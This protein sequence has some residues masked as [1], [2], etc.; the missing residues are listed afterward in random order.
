MEEP[1]LFNPSNPEHRHFIPQLAKIHVACI[2]T[3]K[4]IA[5]FLPP[6]ELDKIIKW[7]EEQVHEV[8]YGAREI[9]MQLVSLGQGHGSSSKEVA[10]FVMLL[11]RVGPDGKLT[12]ET[13]PF[14][15][16]VLKLLV[17]PK[18]RNQGIARRVMTKLEEVAF[19]TGV[20]LL[21]CE[22]AQQPGLR[23]DPKELNF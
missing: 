20:P 10:G 7:Y 4:T 8:E 6:L 1:L 23:L 3:D 11:R 15:A 19:K 9:I 17:S 13:G 22:E 12:T 18:H 16:D 2:E 5:T 14:R 21:V